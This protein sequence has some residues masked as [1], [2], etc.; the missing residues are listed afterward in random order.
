MFTYFRTFGKW[1]C[2]MQA[3]SAKIADLATNW[4][5]WQHPL[6]DRKINGRLVSHMSTSPEN[7]VKIGPEDS[8]ITCVEFGPLTKNKKGKKTEA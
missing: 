2:R 5:L 8:E 3:G 1:V 6:C 4:L 7:L